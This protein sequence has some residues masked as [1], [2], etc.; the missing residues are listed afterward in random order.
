M[1][2]VLR[3]IL[4][5]VSSAII[6]LLLVS[7]VVFVSL[8]RLLPG[9]IAT[10]EAGQYA[11]TPAEIRRIEEHLGLTKPLVVQYGHWLA[12]ALFHG[13]LGTS[14]VSGLRVLSVVAQ[15]APISVELALLGLIVATIIGVP[16]GVLAATKQDRRIDLLIRMP[17]LVVYAIPAFVIG[18]LLLLA[19]AKLFPSLY[20][21]AYIPLSQN[22]LSNLRV[23]ALPALTVG[24]PAAGVLVQMT[25]GSVLTV[26]DEPFV[27]TARAMGIRPTRL[28]VLYVFKAAVAPTLALE[29]F[30]F[31]ILI[32]GVI[33]VEDVFSL[34]GL[35]RGMLD[36][37]SNRDF[38][39]LEGQVLIMA[40]AFVISGLVVDVLAAVVDKRVLLV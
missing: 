16:I 33:V 2:T 34:P 29:G 26:L 27:N 28:N 19:A 32:G 17:S 40:G 21:A 23:M 10:E 25:R 37:I 6:T 15:E 39:L 3:F 1:N 35:G 18:A 12:N 30:L 31:G 11:A 38:L 14:P 36:A 22:V 13:S 4:R 20:F 9:N 8:Q 7:F 5:R 24:T